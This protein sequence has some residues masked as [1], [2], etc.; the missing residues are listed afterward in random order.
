MTARPNQP[1]RPNCRDAYI[2]SIFPSPS[3]CLCLFW[4]Q[5]VFPCSWP[6]RYVFNISRSAYLPGSDSNHVPC[7]LKTQ[8]LD[9]RDKPDTHRDS[10]LKVGIANRPGICV[11]VRRHCVSQRNVPHFT[12]QA[13][14]VPCRRSFHKPLVRTI[15]SCPE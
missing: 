8:E 12:A 2:G 9:V 5:S 15:Q 1:C 11:A 6:S 10:L 13:G 4:V 14:H 3:R 7:H